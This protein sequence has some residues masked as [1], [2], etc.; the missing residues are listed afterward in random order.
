MET[1]LKIG[2]GV[3]EFGFE[4]SDRLKIG[5]VAIA[6][7]GIGFHFLFGEMNGLREDAVAGGVE[8][9]AFLAFD[10]GGAFAVLRVEAIGAETRFGGSGLFR[11]GSGHGG[12]DVYV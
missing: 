10:A 2:A 8:T 3:G 1:K 4:C 11:S 7:F 12:L 6:E 9:R 5:D